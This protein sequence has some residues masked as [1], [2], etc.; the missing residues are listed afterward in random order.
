MI[1]I[2]GLGNPEKKY[3]NTRHNIGFMVLDYYLPNEKWLKK[4][5][6]LYC[7]K[8]I[9]G[10][11]VLFVKPQTYMNNSGWA[12]IKFVNYYNIK[13][14][15]ILI[16]HDDLDLNI[17][18][19]RLKI[20]SRSGGHNGIKSIIENLSSKNFSR[21]KIGIGP[22]NKDVIDFVLGKFSKEEFEKLN[23]PC[24]NKIIDNYLTYGF[25]KTKENI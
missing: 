20:N 7:I 14:E 12:I 1:L 9:N 19:P 11:Q 4:F 6:S 5:N 17:G 21:L 16:I 23:F 2:A 13:L 15:D 8:I 3:I 18:V 25:E 10:K 24:Y 22:K